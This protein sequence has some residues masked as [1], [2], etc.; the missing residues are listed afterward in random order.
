[1]AV[2]F[3]PYSFASDRLFFAP[4]QYRSGG[5]LA[6]VQLGNPNYRYFYMDWY[7]IP[8]ELNQPIW[9]EPYMDTGGGNDDGVRSRWR[10]NPV[11]RG[12]R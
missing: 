3:E 9:T 2:A 11:T 4:Y 12:Q 5:R 6:Y 1:M 7:Q 8:K 10:R